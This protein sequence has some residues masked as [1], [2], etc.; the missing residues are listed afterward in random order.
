MYYR[1]GTFAAYDKKYDSWAEADADIPRWIKAEEDRRGRKLTPVN[2]LP[3]QLPPVRDDRAGFFDKDGNRLT[4]ESAGDDPLPALTE[5][6]N[7]KIDAE[8]RDLIKNPPAP[9]EMDKRVE[10]LLKEQREEYDK[11]IAANNAG[12]FDEDGN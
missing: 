2:D 3:F 1:D 7:K 4:G 5:E 12:F 9:T 8:I 10:Q 11:A 6:Q